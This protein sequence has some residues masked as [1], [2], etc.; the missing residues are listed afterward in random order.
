[1]A[2]SQNS[3]N[4]KYVKNTIVGELGEILDGSILKHYEIERNA[5]EKPPRTYRNNGCAH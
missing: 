5:N 1:M 4:R 3:V 2:P